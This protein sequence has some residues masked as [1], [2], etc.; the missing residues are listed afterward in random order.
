MGFGPLVATLKMPGKQR[1]VDIPGL[2][3]KPKRNRA[4]GIDRG[5][6]PFLV[7]WLPKPL[8]IAVPSTLPLSDLEQIGDCL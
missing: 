4:L 6:L 2:V 1:C 3:Q 8:C 7:W 5:P